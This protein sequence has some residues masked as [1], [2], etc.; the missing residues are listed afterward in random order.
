[1][2]N[3]RRIPA[4]LLVLTLVIPICGCGSEPDDRYEQ[5]VEKTLE[6]QAAQNQAMAKQSQ[7]VAEAS[8]QLVEGDAKAR[9]E[10]AAMHRDLQTGLQSERKNIDRQHDELEKERRQ[11]AAQRHRDPIVAQAIIQVGGYLAAVLPLVFVIVLLRAVRNEDPEALVGELL[12]QEFTSERPLLIDSQWTAPAALERERQAALPL[13]AEETP[14]ASP[15][16]D[17][18]PED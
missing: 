4:L 13:A 9:R 18:K 11:I 14:D 2:R 6:Q 3:T 10:M 12:L 17:E 15:G 8:R 7:E 16:E 5:L 1:M